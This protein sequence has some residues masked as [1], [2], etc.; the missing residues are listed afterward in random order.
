MKRPG[1]GSHT[2]PHHGASVEW[3]TPPEILSALGPFADDPARPGHTDGL[4]RAWHGFVWLNPPYPP[5]AWLDR[6]SQHAPG[7]IA[8]IFAR[9]ETRGFLEYVWR[10]ASSLRF[11]Y[12]RPHFYRNG[13][14]APGNSGGP[15]VLV[16]YGPEARARL[17][18]C[19][20]P[21][22]FA[23]AWTPDHNSL[24]SGSVSG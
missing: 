19:P 20:V 4:I 1:I 22:A 17:C 9:T 16:G 18:A 10:R 15:V 12:G 23:D 2:R 21:G 24:D 11:L 7:G 14:R 8:C 3:Q 6:L 13:V 5:W